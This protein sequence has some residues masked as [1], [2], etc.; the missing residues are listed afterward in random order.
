MDRQSVDPA[1]RTC[2]DGHLDIGGIC[3]LCGEWLPVATCRSPHCSWT[4]AVGEETL[5]K[6]V[7]HHVSTGHPIRVVVN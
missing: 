6:A 2:K 3:G 7:D 5:Q 1:G 4:A